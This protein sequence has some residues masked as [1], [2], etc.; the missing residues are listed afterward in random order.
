MT[1]DKTLKRLLREWQDAGG[2]L[3]KEEGAIRWKRADDIPE[4]GGVTQIAYYPDLDERELPPGM[5]YE[6]VK[7]SPITTKDVDEA[8]FDT[9][10]DS[11]YLDL[12]GYRFRLS[13]HVAMTRRSAEGVVVDLRGHWDSVQDAETILRRVARKWVREQNAYA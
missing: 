13:D 5:E 4:F 12:Y 9:S 7:V 2:W 11:A 1:K 8:P 10:Y 6:L 3:Y